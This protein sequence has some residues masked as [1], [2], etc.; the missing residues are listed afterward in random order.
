MASRRLSIV[1]DL[2]TGRYSGRLATAGSQMRTF[3]GT[4][5]KTNRSVRDLTDSFDRMASKGSSP[6]QMLR[7][8]VLILGNL[9]LAMLNVRDIAVG[10]VA[11]LMKQAGELERVTILMKGL[12]TQ[13]TEFGKNQEAKK[14]LGELLD[15]ARN[16]G[17]ELTTLANAF[18]KFRSADL[19]PKQFSLKGLVDAT[20]AFGG[21][22]DT[23]NRA[24]IA[25]QQMA[26]KGVISMEE[27]RQ[28]LGEAVPSAMKIMALAANKS[29]AEFAK[30]VATGT[31][32][33]K[34]HLQAMLRDME[35]IYAGSGARIA[36]TLFGQLAQVRTNMMALSGDFTQLG[37]KEG[38]FATSVASLKEF[39]QLLRSEDARQFIMSVGN[40][41]AGVISWLSQAAK[42]TFEW[43]NE[44]GAAAKGIAAIAAAM[45]VS[46]TSQWLMGMV[47]Q[48]RTAASSMAVAFGQMRSASGAFVDAVRGRSDVLVGSYGRELAA[49]RDNIAASQIAVA[50]SREEA[51][52]K[53][54]A[55]GVARTAEA[56]ANL[57]AAAKA[58]EAAAAAANVRALEAERVA[59]AGSIN[60]QRQ[61]I[62]AAQTAI[63]FAQRDIDLL[64]TSKA[65]T[66]AL[67]RAKSQLAL[68]ENRLTAMQAEQA[69]VQRRVADAV[70]QSTVAQQNATTA[71][72]AAVMA[73]REVTAADYAA[74]QA[75][76]ALQTAEAGATVTT[77]QLT[78]ALRAKA[79]A[80]AAAAAAGQVLRGAL[81]LL[82]NPLTM[83]AGGL[84]YAAYSAGVF[85]NNADKAA[86]S[87]NR[88]RRNIGDLNDA[89]VAAAGIDTLTNKLKML[90][91]ERNN[92]L[93]AGNPLG[94]NNAALD[95]QIADTQRQIDRL[96]GSIKAGQGGI[97][98][99][100]G[101]EKWNNDFR[102]RT[103][104]F[105]SQLSAKTQAIIQNEKLEERA[106]AG[107]RAAGARRNQL[108]QN[109]A[110]AELAYQR[111]L[112]G[113]L[114]GEWDRAAK[115]G[116]K[117]RQ[118]YFAALLTPAREELSRLSSRADASAESMKVLGAEGAKGLSKLER[119][120]VAADGRTAQLEARMN[121]S[122]GALAKFNAELAGGK[123][124]GAT[125]DQ[126]A[127]MR[128]AAVA[129][130][131]LAAS[132]KSAAADNAY[133]SML[134]SMSAQ[135]AQLEDSL[136]GGKGT[137]AGFNAKLAASSDQLGL[138]ANQIKTLRDLAQH[139]DETKLD[140][141][142]KKVIDGLADDLA[143]AKTEAD[144]LWSSFNSGTMEA[145]QRLAQIRSRFADKLVGLSGAALEDAK[146]KI[147]EIVAAIQRADAA[148][149]SQ[150]WQDEAEQIRISLM[151][152]DAAREANFQ[153][154]LARQQTLLDAI[155]TNA[156]MSASERQAAEERFHN[157]RRAAE[158]RLA[159]EN[160]NGIVRQA[161]Q[162]AN[163]GTNIR[164]TMADALG[165][166]IDSMFQADANFG[167]IAKNMIKTILK[168]IVQAMIAYAILSAIGLANNAQGQPVSFGD[169]MQGQMAGGLTGGANKTSAIG[170]RA[171]TV[172]TKH[173]GGLI[174]GRG[175]V[176]TV[177][178]N[179]FSNAPSYHGG[180][181]IGGRQLRPG[182]VPMIGLEDELVLTQDQQRLLGNQLGAGGQ[183]PNVQVNIINNSGT[184]LDAEQGEPQFNGK[185]MI[186]DVVVEG[187]QRQGRLR[188]AIMAVKP[189]G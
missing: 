93:G 111:T 131:A 72:R 45:A 146:K 148:D 95:K 46:N 5:D 142:N 166:M 62:S 82:T 54:Q 124:T 125:D 144:E 17:F 104:Q 88:L 133:E 87:A 181:W 129:A 34:P 161:R 77:G 61:R 157:W 55:V 13:T 158:A 183:A 182:E 22:S 74:T 109:Q 126:I 103:E 176:A 106:L 30:Q 100:A 149:T 18:V 70:N 1:L 49:V 25:I 3:G 163:L 7:D 38:L 170:Y 15:M 50:T 9:R 143:K 58:R 112:V 21:N 37:N 40:G 121:G 120:A 71:K 185:D 145:D 167:D 151:D 96:K 14:N 113:R 98:A 59:M 99:A 10:W 52:A 130:D 57:T 76:R 6:R 105:K 69:A 35:L 12:S 150:R 138:T 165:S 63:M 16:T 139:I 107:D 155:R 140:I 177:A 85:A 80:S 31:V 41:V 64:G 172:P 60:S 175:Q 86:E 187:V 154:E 90:Q 178:A 122:N 91:S 94:I 168:V 162:W 23:L 92:P 47:S 136:E 48:A 53:M 101:S 128:R 135:L 19:D 11:S 32:Q 115:S 186:L 66:D 67:G 73:T 184:D 164:Q 156:A 189:N 29:M 33:A 102:V 137:L 114:Q 27:L 56:S 173:T 44:L 117:G 127:R 132:K 116:N 118:A 75:V 42:F 159:R 97:M 79:A 83:V 141:D 20:A 8:Y 39:N 2:D 123:Y 153:R 169:F 110:N 119:A 188:E 36:N 81:A 65:R 171:A 51:V 89:K 24:S 180:G 28:Q 147:E 78:V 179:L 134:G 160:E 108:L 4:V 152:E 26:G 43:R 174:G 68:E 84:L